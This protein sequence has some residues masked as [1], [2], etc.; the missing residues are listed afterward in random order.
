MTDAKAFIGWLDRQPSVAKNRKVGTQGYCMGGPIAFRTAAAVP[1]RVGAAPQ[2]F[3]G[4]R[5]VE[6]NPPE[7]NGEQK[8]A[9]VEIL[10]G[11]RGAQ[12]DA[13]RVVLIDRNMKDSVDREV[14]GWWPY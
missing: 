8:R 5:D 2:V 11:L 12:T 13:Y 1:G 9:L 10:T 6:V 14:A 4:C 7:Q 3:I